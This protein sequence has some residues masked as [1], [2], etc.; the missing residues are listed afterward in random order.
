MSDKHVIRKTDGEEIF[1]PLHPEL[2][3]QEFH[4]WKRNSIY[5]YGY[6]EKNK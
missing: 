6:L 5:V 4:G 2:S 1:A 3:Q